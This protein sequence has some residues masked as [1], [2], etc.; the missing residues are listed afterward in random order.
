MPRIS[1][2]KT[3]ITTPAD[4]DILVAVQGGVTK[5]VTLATLRAQYFAAHVTH[6]YSGAGAPGAGDD[7]DDGYAQGSRWVDATSSP[8]E[9]YECV[10]ATA[11]AAVWL[12]ATFTLDE[13]GT[14][15]IRNIEAATAESDFLVGGASP[16]NWVKKT[17]AEARTIIGVTLTYLATLIHGAENKAT[18][19]DADKIPLIDTAASNSLKTSTWTN[20]KAF[21]KTYFDTLYVPTA[22]ALGT[23]TSGD[24]QNCTAATDTTKGVVELATDP[25]GIAGQS[26][27]VVMTPGTTQAKIVDERILG[28]ENSTEKIQYPIPTNAYMLKAAADGSLATATNTDTEVASAV[29]LKHSNTADHTQNTD[30]GTTATSWKINTSGNEADIQTTGLTAD[31]DYTL[32]NIDTMLVGAVVETANSMEIIA[33]T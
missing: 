3:V 8:M 27:A 30:T 21:L 22:G 4:T 17:L 14:G 33:Y 12:K 7:A 28:A 16:F 18:P 24:L 11:G 15:A 1:K 9:V 31:R 20:I 10:D 29:S 32:P 19:I 25:E 5:R 23:P 13:L 2:I 26:D 6:N